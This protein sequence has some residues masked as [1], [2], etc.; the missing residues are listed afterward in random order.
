MHKFVLFILLMFGTTA[1]AGVIIGGTRFIYPEGK[2]IIDVPIRNVSA[3]AWLINSKIFSAQRWPGADTVV[4]S[5]APFVITP[6]LFELAAGQE[7]K[8]RLIRT[9]V[10]LPADRESLFTLSV[11]TIPAGRAEPFSV[12]MAIRSALKLIYRPTGLQG[13]PQQAYAHLRWSRSSAGVTV[14]NPTPFYITLFNVL[15]NGKPIDN[16][17]VVA[18]FTSRQLAWCQHVSPCLLQWQA[19]NDY[20]G[21]MPPHK[22][23]VQAIAKT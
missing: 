15:A 16:A 20:G 13:D 19:L 18:P 2:N 9:A 4:F 14:S 17:G 6:P 10:P 11:A 1:Q 22:A 3:Q 23:D 7:N 12:Q 5:E 8:I 21:V